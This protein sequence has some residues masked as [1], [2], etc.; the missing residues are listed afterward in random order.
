[1]SL[2]VWIKKNHCGD[3]KIFDWISMHICMLGYLDNKQRQTIHERPVLFAVNINYQ[4][5]DHSVRLIDII[6]R[7]AMLVVW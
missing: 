7:I 1:M 2:S 6:N 4:F 3:A 5:V